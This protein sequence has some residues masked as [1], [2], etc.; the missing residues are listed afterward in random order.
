MSVEVEIEVAFF[1]L[2]LWRFFSGSVLPAASRSC[3]NSRRKRKDRPNYYPSP[4]FA[5]GQ[6]YDLSEIGQAGRRVRP[7]S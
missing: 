5:D 6:P 2:A 4:P 7:I 3:A 1:F